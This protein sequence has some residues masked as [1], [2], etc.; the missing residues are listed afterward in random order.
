MIVRQNRDATRGAHNPNA[1]RR[2]QR[3]S[4][5]RAVT[6]GAPSLEAATP[7]AAHP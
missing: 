4:R 1:A 5:I 7:R 3:M 2:E 6:S